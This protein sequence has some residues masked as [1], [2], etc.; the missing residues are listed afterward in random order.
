MISFFTRRAKAFVTREPVFKLTDYKEAG[1]Q[2]KDIILE[3]SAKKIGTVVQQDQ[4]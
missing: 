2:P 1:I 3:V 4:L